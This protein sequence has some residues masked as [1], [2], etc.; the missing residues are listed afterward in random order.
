MLQKIPNEILLE[1]FSHLTLHELCKLRGVCKL[2][3]DCS[4]LAITFNIQKN[5]SKLHICPSSKLYP[6]KMMSLSYSS[7]LPSLDMI[8][9]SPEYQDNNGQEEEEEE[10]EEEESLK[11]KCNP[12]QFDN[13]IHGVRM[14]FHP[15]QLNQI[16]STP[17]WKNLNISQK[18]LY[19]FHGH[20]KSIHQRLYLLP[21]DTDIN[22]KQFWI[23][24]S[25][26]GALILIEKILSANDDGFYYQVKLARVSVPWI[27][28]GYNGP[29]MRYYKST[30]LKEALENDTNI[31]IDSRYV[32]RDTK[33]GTLLK[34]D[35]DVFSIEDSFIELSKDSSLYRWRK[36]HCELL[37]RR[38]DPSVIWKYNIVKEYILG[39][40][41]NDTLDTILSKIQNSELEWNN[42]KN[43]IMKL[44]NQSYSP[45][46][47]TNTLTSK[48]ANLF[49]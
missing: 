27:I 23:G 21:H 28:S 16:Q 25:S 17:S 10:E 48:L 40:S 44:I 39:K 6:D 46:T 22:K 9:F 34:D 20:Y 18:A 4:H 5:N 13:H 7:Y 15:W 29:N 49:R 14:I 43:N 41:S 2:W 35:Q 24:D 1:V 37:N 45:P 33:L 42:E 31:D 36:L 47:I 19:S 12:Y 8:E 32:V 30:K 11:D 3:K 38:R 26:L